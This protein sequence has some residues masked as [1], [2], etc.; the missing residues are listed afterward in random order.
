MK[1]NTAEQWDY[2]DLIIKPIPSSVN[3]REEVD[4]SVNVL[5]RFTLKFP[6]FASPMRAIVDAEFG[7][8][9]ADLGGLC[10]LHRFYDSPNE[11]YLEAEKIS[12]AKLFGLSVGMNDYKTAIDFIRLKPHV[13]LLEVK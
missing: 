4:I 6:V 1:I 13:L 8:K 11:W 9:F 2:D 12:E 10:I 7:K 5:D 3:S